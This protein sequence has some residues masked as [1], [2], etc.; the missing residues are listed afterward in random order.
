M[1]KLLIIH[2]KQFG[3][4]TGNFVMCQNLNRNFEITFLC[5]DSGEEKF[6]V[7]GVRVEYVTAKGNFLQRG[8]S[9]IKRAVFEINKDYTDRFLVYFSFCFLL[10]LITKKEIILDYRT[11]SVAKNSK[12]RFLDDFLKRWESRFFDRIT[13][14]SEGLR[15]F[16]KIPISKV[17]ILPLGANILSLENKKFDAP[18]LFYLGTL[19]NR[20]IEVTLE[21][22]ALFLKKYPQFKKEF[23]YHIVGGGY[24]NEEELLKCRTCSLGIEKNV[25]LHG[26][27][28]H[29]A[30]QHLFDSCNIGISYI[31]MTNY[32][33]H[34]PPTKTFEYIMAGML[35]VGTSTSENKK[36]INPA[37]GVLCNDN[38]VSFAHALK[39]CMEMFPVA[40]STH[41]RETLKEH[42]WIKI[43]ERF[44]EYLLGR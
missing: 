2:K 10:P 1:R 32:F 41:I 20:K 26:Q 29:K 38:A 25:V 15:Q 8:Y 18:R 17:Y 28:P 13:V 22:V 16:L 19:N 30:I 37:N 7:P 9:F 27:K 23:K 6:M 35:C 4:H 14:I 44:K 39:E 24:K 33:D 43:S 42:S 12:K 36:Y 11:G 34:Q 3:Y 21:G 31:P 5:F 40:N